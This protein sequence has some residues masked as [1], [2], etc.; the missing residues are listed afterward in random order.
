[1][2]QSVC[3]LCAT[4]VLTLICGVLFST[5]AQTPSA[6]PDPFAIQLTSSPAGPAA[7]PFSSFAGDIS[8]N[9]RFVVFTSNSDVATEKTAGRN[10]SDG[11]RE[12]FLTDYAQRR[13]FQITNTKNVPK[14]AATPTPSPVPSPS[15]ADPTQVQIEVSSDRP[16]IT[17]AP[18]L[19]ASNQRVFTIVF[20]SNA[21]SPGNFDGV[22]T[23]GALAADGNKE[24]WI[25]RLPAVADVNLSSGDDLPLIDLTT[26]TF[27]RI[28]DTPASRVP[29]AGATGVA[30]FVADDNREATIS[31]NGEVIAFISTRNLVT[32]VGN[33]DGNPELFFVRPGIPGFAQATNTQDVIANGRLVHSVFNTNP[34]LSADGSVAA[35]ASNANLTGGNDDGSGRG[36]AEVYTARFSGGAVSSVFQA[37]R[38]NAGAT[39]ATVNILSPGRRLS[40]NGAFLAFESLAADPKANAATNEPFLAI[41]VYNI[42][43]DA[44]VQIG[45]RAL[46]SPGD[47]IHFPTFTD[48][49]SSLA[50]NTLVF[51]SALNFKT[52][53]TFPAADQ[54]STGLNS[55]PSGQPRPAQIFAT[56]IPAT[57]SNTFTR[58]TKNPVVSLVGGIRPLASDNRKRIAFSLSGT[59]LGGGNAD[60]STEVFYLLSPA[61]TT[62]LGAT[63][64]FFTGA[65]IIPVP[66]AAAS[67]SPTPSPG[68]GEVPGLA[69][70]ELSIVRSTENVAPSDKELLPP[71]GSETTRSP[72]LPVELNGVS[73]SV[74]G[75]AAGL[76]FVGQASKQINFVVPI[77]V[78]AGAATVTINN[79]SNQTQSRGGVLIVLAQPDIF[80]TSNGPGGRAVAFNVTTP[81]TRLGEPFSVTSLDKDLNTV[82]TVLELSLTGV[83]GATLAE[84]KVTIGTT[85]LPADHILFVGPNKEMPGWDIVNFKLPASLAGAGDVPI[86][87]TFTRAG[88]VFTSR[89]AATAPH[90]TIS[91]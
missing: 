56:Q 14:A 12:V 72:A 27:I 83:R 21:P 9:G 91:P 46:I 51:A 22:D 16:M 7:N 30:P 2:K 19:N 74:N 26:G 23:G 75:A 50:A 33:T 67:P 6:T 68:P 66:A 37:T 61:V 49:D 35:F 24:V 69:P 44:F 79:S 63:L 4:L 38:T 15:P 45:S 73:V 89:P 76:Y 62:E 40:R 36:N 13:I 87:V 48:Y 59:E 90:I 28:T 86:I 1:M 32:S 11:N 81:S 34:S 31:D 8:G 88:A 71:G 57:S 60:F 18:A 41:F 70:G 20:S 53:G 80:T 54:D 29:S 3:S 78:A 84:I 52:D 42:A 85:D 47:I 55:V 64:S 39:G 43:T 77:G 58:L 17:F 82:P 25:Y 65:S 5:P 10:N